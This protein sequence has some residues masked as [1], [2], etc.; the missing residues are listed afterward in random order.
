MGAY[1]ALQSLFIYEKFPM[2]I[3]M[4]PT[5]Y[6]TS[7]STVQ[8]ELASNP[9]L[10]DVKRG[11]M[12]D[13]LIARST[14]PDLIKKLL[15]IYYETNSI[16]V[17]SKIVAG[18]MLYNQQHRKEK[19]Y[20]NNRDTVKDFFE[21][22]IHEKSLNSKMADNVVRG[23]IDT[24]SID[25]INNNLEQ[26]NQ[27]LIQVNH[28]SSI[29]LKYS[30]SFKSKEL[31]K[32]YIK[33]IIEELRLANNSDLDSYLFGPLS[34]G[35]QGTGKNLLEPE[36]KQIVIDYLKEVHYK[37]TLQGVKANQSD[38]H[39]VIT[40]PYYFELIKNMGI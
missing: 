38:S 7:A 40:A 24:H 25:E 34:I 21:K 36:T 23:F 2:L 6:V 39:R 14:D 11:I 18:L 37:Y 16:E 33:S 26:I 4:P 15:K 13:R 3:D 19:F 12:I 1:Y 30:L 17:K 35:Y 31:Q 20:I 8:I 32:I 28:Y 5:N 9:E 10:N 27:W 29:M 22:L